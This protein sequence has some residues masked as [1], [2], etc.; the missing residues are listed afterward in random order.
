MTDVNPLSPE[1]GPAA[2]PRQGWKRPVWLTAAF[3]TVA[4]IVYIW[5]KP[6]AVL[7]LPS[8]HHVSHVVLGHF[9]VRNDDPVLQLRYETELSLTDTAGLRQE[10]L[11]LWPRFKVNVANGGY[12]SAAFYAQAPPT[13]PCYRHQGFCS[14]QGF[15]FLIRMNQDARWY[16]DDNDKLLP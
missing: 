2:M 14:Y 16:F 11:E 15:G 7:T 4:F 9:I 13:G 1:V 12:K 8:G 6:W 10:A 3:G 5:P